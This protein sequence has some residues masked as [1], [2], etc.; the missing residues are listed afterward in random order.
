M[1][2]QGLSRLLSISLTLSFCNPRDG[3]T[4]VF[5]LIIRDSRALTRQPQQVV[6]RAEV[7]VVFS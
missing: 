1:D 7:I 6:D 2:E 4:N 3:R 5:F